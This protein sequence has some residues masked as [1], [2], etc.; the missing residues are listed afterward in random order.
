MPPEILW[1]FG[2]IVAA[3]AAESLIGGTSGAHRGIWMFLVGLAVMAVF[4]ALAAGLTRLGRRIPAGVLAA[5]VVL[6][7]PATEVA[8]EHLCGVHPRLGAGT[9]A[10]TSVGVSG[11]AVPTPSTPGGGFHGALFSI[12]LG[13][14]VLGLVVYGFVRFAFVLLPVVFWLAV[15]ALLFMP[16]VVSHPGVGDYILT[17]LLTGIVFFVAGLLLDARM[18]RREA[19]WWYAAG[20]FEIAVAFV[21]YLGRYHHSWTWLT[22]L[23]VALIVL[24]ASAPM[25]RAVWAAYA[26]I[27]VYA[28]IA[29]Y[30]TDV[31][32]AWRTTLL[33]TLLGLLLVFAGSALDVLD[34]ELMRR[35]TRPWLPASRDQPPP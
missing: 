34:G 5:A 2:A 15:A 32:G 24:G 11:I 13:T 17:D 19:F 27:G 23:V 3:G 21:Y 33:L 4:G 8:F 10:S 26:V 16:A 14:A 30:L 1:Y 29:H 7:A 25:R 35:V 18:H 6:V 20:L 9:S 31:T 28:A 12:A 22:L